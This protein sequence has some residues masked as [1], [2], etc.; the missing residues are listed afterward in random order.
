[1]DRSPKDEPT[2]KNLVCEKRALPISDKNWKNLSGR[3]VASTLLNMNI[4]YIALKHIIWGFS[5]CNY[6]R[7]IFR[8]RGFMSTFR[9]FAKS[10]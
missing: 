6:F 4:L 10:V 7:E 3:G 1:M 2:G 8:F 5:I 9:N